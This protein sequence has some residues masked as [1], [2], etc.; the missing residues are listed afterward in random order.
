MF[1]RKND[2]AKCKVARKDS[3]AVRSFATISPLPYLIIH[4]LGTL[5]LQTNHSKISLF[6]KS[7]LGN[8]GTT[9]QN[10]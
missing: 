1:K 3:K 6:Y 4:R 10:Q 7:E 5:Q 2:H 9:L 8:I